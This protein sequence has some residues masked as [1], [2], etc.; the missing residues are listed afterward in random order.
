MNSIKIHGNQ[1]LKGVVQV[2]GS[3]NAAIPLVC[4]SLL[5][6]G[7]VL[8]RNVPRISDIDDLVAI[9]RKLDCNVRFKGHLLMIDNTNLKYKP[10]L[11]EE[12]SKIRGSYYL[13]GVFLT[14]FSKCEI[15]LPGGCKIGKRPIDLHLDA[16]EQL[17]FESKT[18]GNKLFL[19][20][21]KEVTDVVVRL[22][23]KSVGASLNALFSCLATD[24]VILENT[25]FEPEGKDV[26]V[27]LKQIGYCID[28]EED[29]IYYKKKSLDFRFVKHAIIFDR[30]ETMT[31]V[32]MGLLC[33][34]LTIQNAP[35]ADLQYPLEVLLQSGYQISFTGTVIK[36]KKSKG[37]GICLKTAPYPGF[38]TDL[39]ALFGVL[40]AVGEGESVM[41]ECIFENRM[42]IYS[43][44]LK[45][46]ASIRVEGNKVYLKGVN[47][48]AAISCQACDLRHAAALIL[49]GLCSTGTT[50]IEQYD[51]IERGYEDF[52]RKTIAMGAEIEVLLNQVPNNVNG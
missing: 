44:L 36:A 42:H 9:L 46:G 31:Y 19:V 37:K 13:I 12:C 21:K 41:E 15:L 49:M 43:D 8:F 34:N 16:F 11:F 22:K 29:R 17:G 7:K 51:L 38:P 28:V 47:Q 39:Q 50:V 48:L 23:N 14:L 35:V 5:A 26:I 40:N 52:I 30:M 10:L 45:A 4:A 33:G 2:H 25:L 24:Q 1:P 3:K 6:K 27:F 32:I 18:E 20:K